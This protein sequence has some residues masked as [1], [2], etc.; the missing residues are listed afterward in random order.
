MTSCAFGDVMPKIVGTAVE[1]GAGRICITDLIENELIHAGKKLS[2]YQGQFELAEAD[3]TCMPQAD[4]SVDI[5]IIFFLFHELPDP[6]KTRALSEAARLVA[7][8]GKLIIAEF[9]RPRAWLMRLLGRLYFSV[10]EPF[11]LSMW[12]QCDPGY[13]LERTG[14]W[15]MER[16]SYCFGN[17]QILVAT[18]QG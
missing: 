3:A 15:T 12:D 8:G 6:S 13:L 18:K 10:F 7:P 1:G 2:R 16:S 4:G 5:N 14:G 11:A 9:H 17:F